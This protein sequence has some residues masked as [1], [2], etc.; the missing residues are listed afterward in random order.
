M[1]PNTHMYAK[2]ES[3][4][5]RETILNSTCK[6]DSNVQRKKVEQKLFKKKLRHK[7]IY[8]VTC[9]IR[10][11]LQGLSAVLCRITLWN[12]TWYIFGVSVINRLIKNSTMHARIINI[13]HDNPPLTRLL[14]QIYDKNCF[15]NHAFVSPSYVV[16]WRFN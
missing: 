13:F 12:N 15:C 1:S 8:Q 9:I 5:Y 4:S 3:A 11:I 7:Q 16:Y 14:T 10:F 6:F 2:F